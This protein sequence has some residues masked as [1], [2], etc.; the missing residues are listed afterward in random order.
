MKKIV[1]LPLF[2]GALLQ[3]Q[4]INIG[5]FYY[6]DYLDF[7]QNKGSFG[8]GN[9]TLVG[10]D[11]TSLSVPNVPNFA[12]SSNYGSLTSVGRGF[13]VTAN[14][15]SSPESISDLRKWGLTDYNIANQPVSDTNGNDVIGVSKPYGRDEKFIRLDKYVVEG[16]VDMLDT[17]NTTH[18]ND[19]S[20][21]AKEVEYLEQFK[22]E[23]EN[24]KDEKGNIYIY[25]A[26]SGGVTLRGTSNG[27]N[28]NTNDSGELKGGGFGLL[29][30][31]SA[32]Y[33]D[34]VAGFASNDSRGI[35]FYYNP[36]GDFNNRI[37][38][39]DSGSGLYA[40][41]KKNDKWVLVG[42]VSRATSGQNPAETS[43]VSKK[44]L[45]D[46]QKNFEQSISL[47]GSNLILQKPVGSNLQLG[48]TTLQDN[49]DLIFSGGGTI[50]VKSDVNRMV[51][52][53]A[54]GFVFADATTKTTYKFTN[55]QGK[56]YFFK[57]S[58]LDIGEN[59]VVEWALRNQ[60]GDALHKIGKGEL[61]VKTDYT[62]NSNENLGYLK[63]GEGKVTLDTATK[64]FEGVYITSGRGELALVAGKAQAVGAVKSVAQSRDD[65]SALANSYTLAQ[66]STGAMG[67]YFGTGGGKLDLAGNSLTLN[68]IAANDSGAIITN[69]S[70]SLVD[71]EIQGFGYDTNGKKT[72]NKA[73]TIIHASFGEFSPSLAEGAGGGSNTQN[74]NPA[75]INI[76]YNGDRQTTQSVNSTLPQTPSAREGDFK[77]ASAEEGVSLIF[78][79]NININGSLSATN[80][81]IVL[82]GH[83][84]THA[85]IGDEKIREQIE[86]AESGTSQKMPDYMD[87]SK[88][89][90]L[91]QPDWDDRI[92]KIAQ[93]IT[94]ANSAL[95]L[96]R[97][98][99]LEANINATNSSILFGANA[100]HFIDNKDGAN[101]NGSGF[102]YFQQVE[103]GFLSTEQQQIA[104]YTT[105][106]KGTITADA[107][108][109][110]SH[111]F[112]LNASL[113]LKN[114]A[115]LN[116]D[117]L[118]L[119]NAD[120]VT[121]GSG[122]S[123]SIKALRLQGINNDLKSKFTLENGTKFE[124]K[125]SFIFDNSTFNLNF[126]N[127]A[128]AGF[129]MPAEYNLAAL[130]GSKITAT[131]FTNSKENA[132]FIV[133]NSSFTADNM[134]FGKSATMLLDK[135]TLTLTQNL[136][137]A[138]LGL[139]LLNS[140]TI[141]VNSLNSTG[142]STL[143]LD[144]STLMA[145]DKI[146]LDEALIALEKSSINAK[147]MSFDKNSSLNLN[148]NAKLTLT[149][150]LTSKDLSLNLTNTSTMSANTL[151]ASGLLVFNTDESSNIQFNTLNLQNGNLQSISENV[152][153]ST[154]NLTQSTAN[155]EHLS[156]LP[157][158]IDLKT[159]SNLYLNEL[160]LN[161]FS[162]KGLNLTSDDSSLAHIKKLSYNAQTSLTQMPQ[163]NLSVSELFKLDNV[164]QNLG[165]TA[166][167]NANLKDEALKKDLLAFEFD[168][169][170]TLQ[171]S[172]TLEINFAELIKRDNSD[173]QFD[174]FYTLFSAKDLS[175]S[176][177]DF[178]NITFN[179]FGANGDKLFVKGEFKDNAFLVEFR[180]DDPRNFAEL[181]PHI[182]PAYSPLLEIL[183]EHNKFDESIEKAV[184][185]GDYS[186]LN[187]RLARLDKSFTNLANAYKKAFKALPRLQKQE[188]NARIQQNR[189]TNAKFALARAKNLMQRSDV[190]PTLSY[191][192]E[193][194]RINRAW[195]SVGASFFTNKGDTFNLQSVSLG[196]DRRF[197]G[198]EFLLGIMASLTNA[199]LSSSDISFN[200][201]IYTLALYSDALFARGELQNQLSVSHL[202]GDK[203]FESENGSYKSLNSFF[204]SVYKAEISF[205]PQNL[206]PIAL[207][208]L[209]LSRFDSFETASYKQKADNDI[210]VDFGLGVQWLWQKEMGFYTATF[211]AERDIF[212]TQKDAKLSLSHAQHFVEYEINDPSFTYQLY[213]SGS[214][215][216][217][218]GI[219]LRYGI[220]A[221]IDSKAYKG[222]KGDV[223]V[224]YKF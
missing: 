172:A 115:T 203:S 5:N 93:G 131:N 105:S 212:H 184:N 22:K 169:T 95:T 204:E 146:S 211:T 13:A 111:I 125:E 59:V 6:R 150:T 53:Q 11:G 128:G 219:Y 179:F 126:L 100:K 67:F 134:S 48:D 221:Y 164:G 70:T 210:S 123:A 69:S 83:A 21:T 130:N 153:I 27:Q 14:H 9:P 188:I 133:Q 72:A 186:A 31:N 84:T 45:Q 58:G 175:Y 80:S 201:K 222:V 214:D 136:Q 160:N 103:S 94:L 109:I 157:K 54:G 198:D 127:Q 23:L 192:I 149:N 30:I 195:S 224:G 173:L 114:K 77:V 28:F 34:L 33:F 144:G 174:K 215:S 29:N 165:Q 2:V 112:D 155:L 15:V 116:A 37:T 78:D 178:S 171:S 147:D 196:Y 189:F 19:T 79:G 65:I 206:K 135:G 97:N 168:K 43:F 35:F 57:G 166:G 191:L 76:V 39:G 62:P 1:F 20:S 180:R 158:T 87:L 200:P 209:N 121:L 156:E 47:N 139:K 36:N 10:K 73:D 170:L 18:K 120:S 104:N 74:G 208:R 106:Y 40:Y 50:E 82:Q 207:A 119:T 49:K 217:K 81:N 107:T 162:T 194:E 56:N 117:F 3:A 38:S 122:A 141:S 187:T 199:Q 216:F 218:N 152:V 167:A 151:N 16:Q 86:N 25:Q 113:N 68:T 51:S 102:G 8:S 213:L 182:N 137:S 101:I 190:V 61:I 154:L 71:L 148:D 140:S 52:G 26:G 98:A 183:L 124:I 92:F 110:E 177:F 138:N 7:G 176:N 202:N 132:Q 90:N 118:T 223:Q 197:F 41:D 63:L 193:N 85:T 12:A 129:E 96:G 64:A 91:N 185:S 88:P 17:P 142:N 159:Q 46:Y 143:I 108:T 60:S 44:D 89:S 220:S 161:D 181:N 145:T 75:N 163:S 24:F 4:N 66:D 42:V 99:T 55:E 32:Q 205:F